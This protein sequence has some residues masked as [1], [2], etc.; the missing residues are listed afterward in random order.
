METMVPIPIDNFKIGFIG[1]GKMAESIARGVVK[2]GI[3]PASNIRTAHLGSSRRTAFESFGVKVF[4]H[5]NLVLLFHCSIFVFACVCNHFICASYCYET[6]LI[7]DLRKRK[8]GRA[9]I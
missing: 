7:M 5:N 8:P 4:D 2:S 3:V 6:V 1:A 9:L